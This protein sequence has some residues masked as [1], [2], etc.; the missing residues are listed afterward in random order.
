MW[1]WSGA[2]GKN[3]DEAGKSKAA[4]CPNTLTI[5]EAF[6]TSG[7]LRACALAVVCVMASAAVAR[8]PYDGSWSVIFYTRSGV[9]DAAYRSGVIIQNGV[10]YP[11]A[12]GI[13]FNGRVS[14]NGTVRASVSAGGQYANGSGRLGHYSGG[15]VW[16]GE[17]SR[18]SCSGTWAAA[19]RG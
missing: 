1:R 2:S 16:R 11:E 14:S 19:R 13:N 4:L 15:G 6:M 8:S 9:C 3:G 17:G 12:G 7:V 10:I 5:Q 18:G